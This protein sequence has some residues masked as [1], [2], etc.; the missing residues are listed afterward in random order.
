M[1]YNENAYYTGYYRNVRTLG[2][3]PALVFDTIAGFIR[4]N[5]I[6]EIPNNTICELLGITP[7]GLRG[8]VKRLINEGYIEKQSGD[9]RGNKCIYYITE[10]GKLCCPF[11]SLKRETELPVYGQKGGTMLPLYEQKGV[12]ELPVYGQKRGNGVTIKGKRGYPLNKELNTDNSGGE[13]RYTRDTPPHTTT[14]TFENSEKKDFEEFWEKYPE[15]KL[16]PQ[17]KEICQK[18]WDKMCPEWRENILQQ[19]RSGKRW[20]PARGND[21]DNPIWYLRNYAGQDMRGELPFMRQGTMQFSEW[22]ED[23]E[24]RGVKVSLT[25]YDGELAYC[26]TSDLPTMIASGAEFIRNLN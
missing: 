10:K 3:I 16:Y 17:E 5:G 22:L 2:A 25:R 24:R 1:I 18:E 20:R 14:T 6:G 4:D 26:Y 9:G 19:L 13:T 23:A 8:I 15:A 7:T 21:G 12:M 11:M